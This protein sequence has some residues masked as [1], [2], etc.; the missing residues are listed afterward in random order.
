MEILYAEYGPFWKGLWPYEKDL[1]LK[2]VNRKIL[3]FPYENVTFFLRK[4]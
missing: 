2:F 1:F 4:L 3:K